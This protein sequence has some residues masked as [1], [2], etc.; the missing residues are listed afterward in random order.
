M[1]ELPSLIFTNFCLH[2]LHTGYKKVPF[3]YKIA[4]MQRSKKK[5]P[6]FREIRN[7][8]APRSGLVVVREFPTD[9]TG[10]PQFTWLGHGKN[11]VLTLSSQCRWSIF[12]QDTIFWPQDTV[13]TMPIVLG[14]VPDIV[15]TRRGQLF[16]LAFS[17]GRGKEC[18][19]VKIP[20]HD[21]HN[22]PSVGDAP[23]TPT[24]LL[25]HDLGHCY[26][27]ELNEFFERNSWS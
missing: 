7:G 22:M 12:L 23:R 24:T 17:R 6:F 21:T 5:D 8:S 3:F 26:D 11:C 16:C 20:A 27:Q 4:D 9:V 19:H 2:Y 1:S 14:Q 13:R 15:R 10:N 25:R 18:W